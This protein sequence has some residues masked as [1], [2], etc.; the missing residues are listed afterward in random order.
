MTG[1][2]PTGR[3]DR[4]NPPFERGYSFFQYRRGGIGNS[5]VDMA[6]ALNIKQ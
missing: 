3:R 6:R 4:A 5:R 2:L 1:G